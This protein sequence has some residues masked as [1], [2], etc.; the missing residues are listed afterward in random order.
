MTVSNRTN[1]SAAQFTTLE[2]KVRELRS[3]QDLLHWS[4]R[5]EP[6]TLAPG[7][8]SN[9][10]VQDEFT[11]DLIVPWNELYLVLGTT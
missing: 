9:L 7:V 6:G 10:V 5:Q 8:I 2:Q 1:L 11:H 3:L 4:M